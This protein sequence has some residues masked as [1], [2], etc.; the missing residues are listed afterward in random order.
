M[1]RRREV[2]PPQ[3]EKAFRQRCSVDA[4]EWPEVARYEQPAQASVASA[5]CVLCHCVVAVVCLFNRFLWLSYAFSLA[6]RCLPRG[7]VMKKTRVA[8][9][10]WQACLDVGRCCIQRVRL[11]NA[12]LIKARTMLR[13]IFIR[14]LPQLYHIYITTCFVPICAYIMAIIRHLHDI[15][16][17]FHGLVAGV[18]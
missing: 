3:Q 11:L 8:G 7:M 6:F 2:R 9:G 1:A 10:L 13:L 18:S 16:Q 12:N 15:L 5:V 4:P 17:A 14:T